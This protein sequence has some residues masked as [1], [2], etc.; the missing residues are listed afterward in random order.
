MANVLAT[1]KSNAIAGTGTFTHTVV[2]QNFFYVSCL[3]FDNPPAGTTITIQQNGSTISTATVVSSAQPNLF[4]EAHISAAPADV[5]SIVISSS[6]VVDS[7]SD[8]LK[9]IMIIRVGN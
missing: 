7:I 3:T 4:C 8:R 9:S 5:L 1:Q 2:N 6:Q